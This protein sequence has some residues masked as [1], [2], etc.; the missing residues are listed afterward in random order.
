METADTQAS[1]SLLAPKHMGGLE[2]GQGHAFQ[3]AF[4][5]SRIPTW[6]ADPTVSSILQEGWS[7]I[8]VFHED[9]TRELI[10]VKDARLGLQGLREVLEDFQQRENSSSGNLYKKYVVACSEAVESV[11]SLKRVIDRIHA[12]TAYTDEERTTSFTGLSE[13]VNRYKLGRFS[14]ILQQKVHIELGLGWLN[15]GDQVRKLLLGGILSV[16]DLPTEKA[17]EASVKIQQLVSQKLGTSLEMAAIQAILETK[18]AEAVSERTS[19]FT[20]ITEDFLE[21]FADVPAHSSFYRGAIP[22][23]VDLVADRDIRR[24]LQEK[25]TDR[26]LQHKSRRLLVP[27]LAGG[28]EGK[29]TFLMRMAVDLATSGNCVLFMRSDAR[30]VSSKDL[31]ELLLPSASQAF[32]L[33]DNASRVEGLD[34][35]LHSVACLPLKPELVVVLTCRTYEWSSI[36]QVCRSGFDVLFTQESQPYSLSVLSRAEIASLLEKLANA[37][38]INPVAPQDVGTV[39]DYCMRATGGKMLP[40]VI[41]LTHGKKVEAIIQEE[42]QRV[43]ECGSH[44]LQAYRF[45]CLCA[46]LHS[47]ITDNLLRELTERDDIVLD[48]HT[49]LRGLA[50][51]TG[52]RVIPRHETIGELVTE[53]LYAGLD[54]SL[55]NDVCRLLGLVVESHEIDVLK[56]M[57]RWSFPVPKSQLFRVVNCILDAAYALGRSDLVK[58][59]LDILTEDFDNED[60]ALEL[61]AARTPWIL[62]QFVFRF[63]NRRVEIDFEQIGL[64]LDRPFVW[65]AFGEPSSPGVPTLTEDEAFDNALKWAEL[66]ESAVYAAYGV[67]YRDFIGAVVELVYQLLSH[68]SERRKAEALCKYAD[69]LRTDLRDEAACEAYAQALAV[70]ESYA[71]AHVGLAAALYTTG[72]HPRAVTHYKRAAQLDR[73]AIYADWHGEGL[74][75]ELLAYMDEYEE[76]VELLKERARRSAQLKKAL[77]GEWAKLAPIKRLRKPRTEKERLLQEDLLRETKL[78]SLEDV[79]EFCSRC[80]RMK[81][82]LASI[83]R[84]ARISF[85]QQKGSRWP[86]YGESVQES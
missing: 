34:N 46:S 83:P 22:T 78:P 29:S 23:W 52:R 4:V 15:L 38:E 47:A 1:E 7:D 56:D 69:F 50:E 43:R 72:D 60:V 32:V 6:L 55:G 8:E 48:L 30:T 37:E 86:F 70:D 57:I 3:S 20:L 24:E 41:E 75:E 33:I 85:F 63:P 28:G 51:K 36:S 16:C 9:E 49:T 76:L 35:L 58:L 39:I 27:V 84:E 62:E 42:L 5:I 13:L 12:T 17:R 74:F 31:D 53:Q 73:Q 61:L 26:I 45:I 54:E 18:K 19:P 10:Q 80:D 79:E 82:Y 25:I 59:A 2:A 40:L 67:K 77:D 65:P 11:S 64:T 44:L 71:P 81:S 14:S 68:L 66:Y 21:R